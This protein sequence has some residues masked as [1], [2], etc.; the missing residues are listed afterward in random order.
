M[1][2]VVNWVFRDDKTYQSSR[3]KRSLCLLDGIHAPVVFS[4][5]KRFVEAHGSLLLLVFDLA[6]GLY[7][8]AD[9]NTDTGHHKSKFICFC[10]YVKQKS[11]LWFAWTEMIVRNDAGFSI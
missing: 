10:T 4:P 3:A 2:F 1:L 6:H 5:L 9:D 7:S 8:R 11:L